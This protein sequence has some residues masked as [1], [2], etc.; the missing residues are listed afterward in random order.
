MSQCLHWEDTTEKCLF[1]R[2]MTVFCWI[3]DFSAELRE[4]ISSR[5]LS[6]AFLH[7]LHLAPCLSLLAHQTFLFSLCTWHISSVILLC[8]TSLDNSGRRGRLSLLSVWYKSTGW[9]WMWLLKSCHESKFHPETHTFYSWNKKKI[10]SGVEWGRWWWEIVL[11]H[12][13][14]LYHKMW[15]CV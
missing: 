3:L 1:T 15:S 9:V 7:N 14:Q 6:W 12:I 5:L 11:V 8:I 4:V 2:I 13:R 10:H